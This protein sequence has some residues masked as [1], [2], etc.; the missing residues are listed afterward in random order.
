VPVELLRQPPAP[1]FEE[2]VVAVRA[3]NERSNGQGE[4][5]TL[6]GEFEP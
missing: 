6:F 2:P 5:I 3:A 1:A 4:R